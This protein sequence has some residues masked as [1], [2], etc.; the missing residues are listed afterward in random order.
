MSIR[1][2]E[3]FDDKYQNARVKIIECYDAIGKLTPQ[4]QEK[5]FQEVLEMSGMR[6]FFAQI[7]RYTNN[8]GIG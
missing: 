3:E 5:L 1:L 2:T 8:G 7:M 4:Q 6:A